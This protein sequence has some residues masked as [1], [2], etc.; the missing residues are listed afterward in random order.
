MEK[1]AFS[2]LE[3]R[4]IIKQRLS[5]FL[6]YRDEHNEELERDGFLSINTS[7]LRKWQW[8]CCQIKKFEIPRESAEL[9]SVMQRT[10]NDP[11][12]I[13]P[14]LDA[15]R[16]QEI[17]VQVSTNHA[18][19]STLEHLAN[20]VILLRKCFAKSFKNGGD[21]PKFDGEI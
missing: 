5:L 19:S 4:I 18:L 9:S 6:Q 17:E 16:R 21:F 13:D 10:T 8:Q 3:M 20:K 1:S 15:Q 12:T 2:E 7:V 11:Q 14:V